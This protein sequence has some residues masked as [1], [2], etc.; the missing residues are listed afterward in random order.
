MP[1]PIPPYGGKQPP[2]PYVPPVLGG[3]YVNAPQTHAIRASQNVGSVPYPS[4][5]SIPSG[6]GQIPCQ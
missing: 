6:S 4:G 2:P 3:P 5:S 1:P